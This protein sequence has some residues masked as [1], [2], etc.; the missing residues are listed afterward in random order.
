VPDELLLDSTNRNE[1][2]S[3]ALA[4]TRYREYVSAR[5]VSPRAFVMEAVRA[6]QTRAAE[7]TQRRSARR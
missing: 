7:R 2:A 5:L 4:R 3:G 6:K 1:F